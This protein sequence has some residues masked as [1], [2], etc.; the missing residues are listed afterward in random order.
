[1][2]FI[3][4]LAMLLPATPSHDYLPSQSTVQNR[5]FI[6]DIAGHTYIKRDHSADSS[7]TGYQR[8]QIGGLQKSDSLLRVPVMVRTYNKEGKITDSL[9]TQYICK[10]EVQT[11]LLNIITLMSSGNQKTITIS[12]HG[13]GIIFPLIGSTQNSLS[14]LSFTMDLKGGVIGFLGGT[15]KLAI[16]NRKIT[17]IDSVSYKYSSEVSLS[18]YVLGIRVKRFF[19]YSEEKL[20]TRHG[21]TEQ[22]FRKKDGSYS[23]IRIER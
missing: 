1:M 3:V 22:L 19:Y 11:V 16:T 10:P 17:R 13:E 23:I 7:L 12:R 20:N 4:F 21:L 6:Y 15:S 9:E 18:V 5:M 14:N 2:L 8:F